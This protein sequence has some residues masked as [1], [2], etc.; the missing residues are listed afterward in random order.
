MHIASAQL[1]AEQTSPSAQSRLHWPQL[2]GSVA[3]D[4]QVVPQQVP[5]PPSEP[6]HGRIEVDAVHVGAMQRPCT[7]VRLEPHVF[8]QPPQFELSVLVSMHPAP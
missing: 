6:E 4:A 1:P 3:I 8:P 5:V 2:S 7:Q